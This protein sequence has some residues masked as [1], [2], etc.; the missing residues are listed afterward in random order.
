MN[1]FY[2]EYFIVLAETLNFTKAS[3]KLNITQPSLSKAIMSIEKNLEV[4]LFLRNKRDVHLTVAGEVF[5]NEIKNAM[6]NF[7]YAVK[8]AKDADKCIFEAL[9]VGFSVTAVSKILPKILNE[10]RKKNPNVDV[11]LVDYNYSLLVKALKEKVI[12]IA[13][14]PS[15]ELDDNMGI[16]KQFLYSDNMC[17]VV[18][19][20][21]P[22]AKCES[23]SIKKLK[24]EPFI[25]MNPEY[26][27]HDFSLLN[28]ICR[29][30]GFTPNTV[31]E[32]NS[33]MN[34]LMMVECEI[35]ITIL[36]EHMQNFTAGNVKFV[37]I[38][39]YTNYFDLIC[40][41]IEEDN[42]TINNFLKV[43]ATSGLN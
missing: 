17:A 40:A 26:S 5:Y 7:N 33:L 18:Y 30:A 19:K 24:N 28:D 12:D 14:L 31:Y 35:G 43:V 34:M 16:K 21:H 2:F 6:S 29:E 9:S 23:I 10:Y 41:Y 39:E 27:L 20:D 8:K 3:Q 4:Q 36:A 15:N 25:N 1:L 22:L 32:S 11:D 37:K 13:I 42:P 38:E